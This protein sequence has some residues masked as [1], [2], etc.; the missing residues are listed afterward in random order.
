[1]I[2]FLL[3]DGEM[4][5]VDRAINAC[6]S[7]RTFSYINTESI[8][9]AH[10]HFYR[11]TWPNNYYQA[12]RRFVIAVSG[13]IIFK[14]AH[15][16]A[17]L[18][19]MLTCLL[20]GQTLEQLF[21]DLRGPYTLILID[22]AKE[23]VCLL[24]S[25]EGLKHCYVSTTNSGKAFSTNLLLL[26]ALTGGAPS[27]EGVRQ[28][29][30][31]GMTIGQETLFANV[32]RVLPASFYQCTNRHWLE[33]RLWR[34][35]VEQPDN[36]MSCECAKDTII[37]SFVS[38][39]SFLSNV[40]AKRVV[41]DLT[42]GTDSRLVLC[43]LTEVKPSAET[44]TSGPSDFIDVKIARKIAS[45]L[46]LEHYWYD[47]VPR[48]LT[49]SS[50]DRAVELTDGNMNPFR[51]AKQLE[52]YEEKA[53]RFD[54]ITGGGGGG[55][56][57]DHYWL[58]EFNRIGLSRE[59]N[60]ERIAKF[61]L[62]SHLIDDGYF[63]NYDDKILDNMTELFRRFSSEIVGTNNQK[64]DFVY[65]DLKVPALAGPSFSLTTQFMDVYHP[66]LDGENVQFSIN[67]PPEIRKNNILQFSIIQSLRP[68]IAWILTN[69]GVPAVPPVNL[70][71]GL[72][73]LRGLRYLSTAWRKFRT[74]TVGSSGHS[75]NLPINAEDIK[76]MG[77]LDLLDYPSLAFSQ[78]ISA[79]K[80]AA[81]KTS[82]ANDPGSSYLLKTLAAQLFFSRVNE[83]KEHSNLA[84]N[85]RDTRG[86]ENLSSVT[87]GNVA[88]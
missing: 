19:S 77:Y 20:L 24:N 44:T 5:S 3:H 16:N 23:L 83:I 33:S 88:S 78:F 41:A 74:L 52:Y 79:P 35:K 63:I 64:L 26:A 58:F 59:P 2:G 54:F 8:G 72:R 7:L 12:D 34:L 27:R 86:N 76:R 37:R 25:R 13:T 70:Y 85:T 62:V 50:L 80:L 32:N 48:E 71:S 55:L 10:V 75:V 69:T 17:A 49:Q 61:S 42:G 66:M 68:E 30:H 4:F 38:G 31:L 14:H 47:P 22:R 29:I 36:L 28:F 57:K 53:G 45:R 67:L 73:A 39:F 65:F 87:S 82:P 43:C 60:W 56:F 18:K 6:R 1:M 81:F 84:S 9:S 21:P 46:G 15:G 40:D 51:L 11:N